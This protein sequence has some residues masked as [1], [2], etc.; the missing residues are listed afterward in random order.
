LVIVVGNVVAGGAGKTPVTIALAKHLLAQGFKVGVISRGHGRKTRDTRAVTSKSQAL[1]VG[2]EPLLIHQATSAPVWVG[3]ARANAAMG[4]LQAHPEVQILLCDDGLQH[5][6]LARDL[7]ICVMDERGI[8]NGMS[9]IIT[10]GILA[11]L[12]AGLIQAWRTFAQEVFQTTFALFKCSALG[13]QDLRIH[14]SCASSSC[15]IAP[16]FICASDGYDGCNHGCSFIRCSWRWSPHAG[17]PTT[18][19]MGARRHFSCLFPSLYLGT[20][21]KSFDS[22][23]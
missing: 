7:E 15:A 16:I 11:Q 1:D 18:P 23:R 9:I 17:T 2:D 4:L 5:L 19:Q 3:R 14:G 20:S 10:V 12:P 13:P 22:N 8:G 6:A 21:Y